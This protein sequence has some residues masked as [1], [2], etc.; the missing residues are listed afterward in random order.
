[1]EAIMHISPRNWTASLLC[2]LLA[3]CASAPPPAT[4][5]VA[6]LFDDARFGAPSRPVSAERLFALSAPMTA[7]LDSAT[8]RNEVRLKGAENGLIEALYERQSLQLEYDSSVTRDAAAT[9]EAKRGNCL[10]LVIMTA[11]FAKALR[12]DIAFQDVQI[13]TEWSRKSG[14]YV[15]NKHVNLSVVTP[16]AYTSLGAE[17]NRVTI[18]FVPPAQ[19]AV[20]RVTRISENTIVAMYINNRAAEEF[21]ASR[22]NDA[23]WWARAAVQREPSYIPAYNT[24]GVIY[25]HGGNLAGAERVFRRALVQ[26]PDDTVLLTNLIPALAGQGKQAESQALALRLASIDPEPPFHYFEKGMHALEA[27]QYTEAKK[28]F[29][30]EVR[31]AP[32]NHEFHYW[33]AIAH[34]RLGEAAAAREEMGI[35]LANANSSDASARYSAKLTTLRALR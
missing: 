16:L 15:G 1:L 26:A 25:Q 35:A 23:Y 10:S 13:D 9:F 4:L 34:L 20:P 27:G 6:D 19:A 28:L 11:A 8:F 24:L 22:V 14:L 31:R 33:L 3:G 30:R 21:A 5:P 32:L 2:L 29:S 7:Y 12:L 17:R 18:D